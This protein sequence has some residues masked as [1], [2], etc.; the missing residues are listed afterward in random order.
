MANWWS[1][2][3]DI[4]IV[5]INNLLTEKVPRIVGVVASWPFKDIVPY[6]MKVRL[7]LFPFDVISFTLLRSKRSLRMKHVSAFGWSY[8]LRYDLLAGV[9]TLMTPMSPRCTAYFGWPVQILDA[10]P[11]Q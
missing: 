2:S 7:V 6:V 8:E 1:K 3:F 9:L 4:S 11:G 10:V 5:Q